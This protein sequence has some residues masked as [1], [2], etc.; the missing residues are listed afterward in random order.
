MAGLFYAHNFNSYLIL[1][2]FAIYI[3]AYL[4]ESKKLINTFRSF[5]DTKY[6]RFTLG[7]FSRNHAWMHLN[8]ILNLIRMKHLLEIQVWQMLDFKMMK[9]RSEK[10]V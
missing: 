10:C 3:D 8:N 7:I 9:S 4:P 6:M 1:M 2:T 5:S